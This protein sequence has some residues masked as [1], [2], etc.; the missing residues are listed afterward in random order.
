MPEESPPTE[1]EDL[2]GGEIDAGFV[3]PLDDLSVGPRHRERT[4][5]VLAWWLMSILAGTGILHY[6]TV[7]YLATHGQTTAWSKWTSSKITYCK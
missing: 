2:E 5:S 7:L 3:E 1:S 6:G 4:A